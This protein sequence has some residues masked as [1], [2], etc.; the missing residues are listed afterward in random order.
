MNIKA[1]Q[2][3]YAGHLFR[4]RL[5][6]RWAV[7][8]DS[9]GVFWK[10][11]PQGFM[12]GIEWRER[13]YLPDFYLPDLDLWVEVKGSDESMDWTLIGDACDGAGQ[14]LPMSTP[15]SHNRYGGCGSDGSAV[16][17][18]GDIPPLGHGWCH[19]MLVNQKGVQAIPVGW[20][21]DGAA[22]V[23][24]HERYALRFY[25][26][27]TTG[28]DC[29]AGEISVHGFG[30]GPNINPRVSQAFNAARTARFEH[31]QSGAA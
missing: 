27:T 10:Y 2:T 16:L 30:D 5:E 23:K 11:E 7:F 1:I 14:C 8:F 4:S 25:Y 26:D 22:R 17:V 24:R 9:L 21:V 20:T 15:G 18:L 31:G 12:V 28:D 13:P 19:W 29:Y 6:A 3:T